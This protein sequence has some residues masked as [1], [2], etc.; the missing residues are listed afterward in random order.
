M[1][2]AFLAVLLVLSFA[3]ISYA[4]PDF[5]S[6]ARLPS[7]TN[8]T[9]PKATFTFVARP[10]C[11]GVTCQEM[12]YISLYNSAGINFGH[13]GLCAYWNYA[14]LRPCYL[15]TTQRTVL[16]MPYD[17]R[18]GYRVEVKVAK[19]GDHLHVTWRDISTGFT[20][21]KPFFYAA[22]WSDANSK[23]FTAVRIY[24]SDSRV[25]PT[26]NIIIENIFPAGGLFTSD[27]SD[28][29]PTDLGSNGTRWYLYKP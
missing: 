5:D 6:V 3:E 24:S 17:F 4:D 27:S 1:N 8:V 7:V 14:Y 18:F 15:L 19:Q 11:P 26:A 16:S 20:V 12:S 23:S 13:F 25:N 10:S 9:N 22:R 21:S 28:Y 29:T 2:K